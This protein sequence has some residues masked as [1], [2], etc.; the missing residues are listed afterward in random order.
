M[1]RPSGSTTGTG[2]SKQL[3]SVFKPKET[4]IKQEVDIIEQEVV[5]EHFSKKN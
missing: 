4:I 1:C 5:P 3:E 2:I